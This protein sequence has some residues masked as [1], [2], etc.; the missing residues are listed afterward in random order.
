MELTVVTSTVSPKLVERLIQRA[1]AHHPA[2]LVYVDPRSFAATPSGTDHQ[3]TAQLLR[4][5]RAGIPVA[6]LR[7]G[8]DLVEKLTP[9]RPEAAVG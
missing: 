6:V 5:E 1:F 3:A 2:T 9:A 4:L 8:D 7:R